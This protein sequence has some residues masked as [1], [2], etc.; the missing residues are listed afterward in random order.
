MTHKFSTMFF[1]F[2]LS[3]GF[4]IS[5][6]GVKSLNIWKYKTFTGVKVSKIRLAIAG[7][8]NCASSLVQGLAYYKNQADNVPGIM[9]AD[10]CGYKISD[11]LPVAA[12]DIDKRKVGKDLSQAIFSQPNCTQ[13]FCDVPFMDVEVKMS[14]VLDGFSEHMKNY[15]EERRFVLSDE[16]PVDI[17][18]ELRAAKAD[19]LVNYMPV[20]SQKAVENLA[21]ACLSAGVAMVNCM[22]VFIASNKEWAKRFTDAKLPIVGDDI[23]SEV[24]ATIVHRVLTNLFKERG[25]I[26]DRTYQ[27]NF[28]G[29]TDFMNMLERSRLKSKKISKTQS[30]QS[31]L[32][33]P[34][35]PEQI[36]IGPSD[37]VPWLNDRKICYI[38]MEGRKFGNV[39]IELELRL[40]VEDSPNSASC[41]V[42]AIRACKVG[43]DRNIGGPLNAAS[44]WTMKSP[45]VQFTD[46]QAK[47]LV[48]E[49]IAVK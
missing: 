36:H 8:G 40:S 38:R 5:F 42:D 49:F 1:L 18:E 9:H 26:L 21:E 46:A 45:P 48:E 27:L 6:T 7:V 39:P 17:T 34:L 20:G 37:Y 12:F 43:L 33:E 31:Q 32:E 41:V 19:V 47:K 24:G 14:S 23:K 3:E 10:F 30:V 13:K 16:Q 44:A 2:S 15:P 25:V 11:I 22:P 29:N 4:S 28:G 35:P